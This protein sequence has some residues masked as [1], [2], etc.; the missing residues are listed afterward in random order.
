MKAAVI[1]EFGAANVLQI[2][3]VPKPVAGPG[4]ILVEVH[5]ASIN[6]IDWK[7]REGQ[8]AMRYGS[9]FPMI[10]GWDVSGI[11]AE[12]GE[13]VAGFKPGDAVFGRSD[14]GA[15]G[16]YAE[17]AVLNVAT[18]VHKPA[19]LSHS[20]AAAIPLVGLTVLNG[21]RACANLQAG[22]RVLIVGASGGVGTLAVQIAK[23]MGAEVTGACSHKNTA[24]VTSLGADKVVAYDRDD[25]LRSDKPYDIVYDAVG[26]LR[27][28]DARRALTERGTYLTLVPVPG[29]DFFIPGQTEW[30]P[31]RAYFV[32][33]FPKADDLRLLADWVVAGCLRPVIDSTF[34]LDDIRA[35]H[36]R[37]ETE[38]AVGKIVVKVR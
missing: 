37:S 21:L 4:Q 35:A 5:A 38:R 31:G 14:I 1:N 20:E 10:L 33:W 22:Q 34:S 2:R 24:L 19:A 17:Y 23:N 3:E 9:D 7:M 29:I 8:M 15:G 25:P 32:A 36:E 18:V 27:Y 6:P 26:A 11:V 16:C 12:S 30:Q 28:D 13:G